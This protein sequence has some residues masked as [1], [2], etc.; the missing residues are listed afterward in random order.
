MHYQL[1]QKL[2]QQVRSI[3]NSYHPE[4]Q[5]EIAALLK[6]QGV[7]ANQ[8]SI[9]RCLRQLGATKFIDSQGRA[10][11]RLVH[12]NPLDFK[13]VSLN[14]LIKKIENNETTIV[15][16]TNQGAAPFV[17]RFI[18]THLSEYVL[19]TIAGDDCVFVAPRST[20][21]MLGTLQK[22]RRSLPS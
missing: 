5:Q 11:Y 22:I 21:K 17:A 10:S 18:D 14:S 19:G 13:E 6:K 2:R 15:V 3:L 1:K 9:S 16:T 7:R 8:S 4:T 20:K 12:D